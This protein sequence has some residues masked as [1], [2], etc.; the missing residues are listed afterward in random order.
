MI[1]D[2]EESALKLKDQDWI[3]K[4]KKKKKKSRKGGKKKNKHIRSE[5]DIPLDYLCIKK[6]I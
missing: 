6:I 2:L 5:E 4:G 1:L 3:T